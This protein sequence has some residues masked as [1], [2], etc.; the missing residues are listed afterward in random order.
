MTGL[1][2]LT[3]HRRATGW[4]IVRESSAS[5]VGHCFCRTPWR[6][7]LNDDRGLQWLFSVGASEANGVVER[8]WILSS[9]VDAGEMKHEVGNQGGYFPH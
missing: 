1:F 6:S 3:M 9:C 7:R 2:R 8:N 4:P 5:W